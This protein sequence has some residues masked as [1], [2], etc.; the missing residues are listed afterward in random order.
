MVAEPWRMT[1]RASLWIALTLVGCGGAAKAPPC[2]AL[3]GGQAPANSFP[4]S[5]SFAGDELRGAICTN[6]AYGILEQTSGGSSVP[7]QLRLFVDTASGAGN[8]EIESPSGATDCSLQFSAGLAAA[9]PGTYASAD[10]GGCDSLLLNAIYPTPSVD[11]QGAVYPAQCP[12]GCSYGLG[13][14]NVPAPCVPTPGK[15]IGYV[16]QAGGDCLGA[17]TYSKLGSWTLTLTSVQPVSS[18][19]FTAHG[20]LDATVVTGHDL[21]TGA[22]DGSVATATL[23]LTF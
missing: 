3:A 13:S 18:D 8:C 20:T 4:A 6:G 9:A 22:V 2:T 15:Q 14:S 23:S 10:G 19:H 7:S 5:G 12:S 17:E 1:R 21:Y 16:A 11:C